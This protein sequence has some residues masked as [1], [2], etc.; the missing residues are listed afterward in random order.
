[1][2]PLLSF[3]R[4]YVRLPDLFGFSVRLHA[5]TC[6]VF[7]LVIIGFARSAIPIW[8]PVWSPGLCWLAAISTALCFFLSLLAHE[9][10]HAIMAR[11]RG[12]QVSTVS[13]F[14]F[15]G[16]S[17]IEEPF[18]RP[19]DELWI[20]A[21][22]P[23]VSLLLV[24]VFSLVAFG[25]DASAFSYQTGAANIELELT[26]VV[27][28]VALWLAAINLALALVNL[29]PGFPLDGGRVFRALVWWKTGNRLLAVRRAAKIGNLFGWALILGGGWF[30]VRGDII[31]GFWLI[32][33]G[34]FID[35]LATAS[36]QAARFDGQLAGERINQ[37][38]RTRYE[39]VPADTTFTDFLERFVLRSSQLVWPVEDPAN[40]DKHQ[41]F[42]DTTSLSDIVKTMPDQTTTTVL[43]RMQEFDSSNSMHPTE[44]V[45]TAFSRFTNQLAPVPVFDDG[46]VV[47]LVDHR[48]LTRWL[49][50][51]HRTE[52][53]LI[54][55]VTVESNQ[56][57]L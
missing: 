11:T 57:V 52:R 19:S 39:T 12:Y 21:V 37:L 48:G 23:L 45:G 16:V 54:P 1:M 51:H 33:A 15:G 30:A 55:G 47:G 10:A 34:W 44:E 2:Q 26:S 50:L 24:M 36:V 22:G 17:S 8:H 31:N 38:M 14:L 32:V 25:F 27:G 13:L 20:A 56:S 46:R 5:S 7:I 42:I 6:T 3:S 53:G 18:R 40:P 35:H 49:T 41:G 43:S 4:G 29:V 9:L 28:T